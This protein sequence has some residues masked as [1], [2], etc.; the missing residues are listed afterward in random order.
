MK[1]V[2]LVEDNAEDVHVFKLGLERTLID[3]QLS[4]VFSAK[5]LFVYL[6]AFKT[7][8][9]FL[10]INMPCEDGISCI[11]QIRKKA[12]FNNIPVVMYSGIDNPTAIKEAMKHGADLFLQKPDSLVELTGNLKVIFETDW[13]PLKQQ[14]L[15]RR[16][17]F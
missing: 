1:K 15:A 2:L 10:D 11:E 9:I 4:H 12:E 5:E 6:S 13:K 8:I 7:D 17:S 16:I 14:R 3:T